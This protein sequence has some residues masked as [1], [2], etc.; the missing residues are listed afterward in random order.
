MVSAPEPIHFELQI[1][2]TQPP[3]GFWAKLTRHPRLLQFKKYLSLGVTLF[4]VLILYVGA[5]CI[6]RSPL[7]LVQ[8]IEIKNPSKNVPLDLQTLTNLAA[9]PPGKINL[10][11]L[12]LKTVE[13][14]LIQSPWI[15]H[16]RLEKQFPQTLAIT[17][18]YREP[19][20]LLQL[21]QGHLAY[22]DR[23]GKV[24]GKLNLS[25]QPD[26]PV[27]SGML[28][29]QPAQ[30]EKA[31]LV[32]KKWETSSLH[33]LTQIAGM[34]YDLQRGFRALITYPLHDKKIARTFVNLGTEF[35]TQE[36]EI[37]LNRLEQV[38]KY[39][40][41]RNIPSQQI[42]ADTGKKIIVKIAP[43]S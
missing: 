16:V 38:F 1:L 34:D 35:Q 29:D 8:N 12:H 15:R 20:A 26:L 30:I 23:D 27:F 5:S 9:V 28:N 3:Q 22:I 10:F 39:L 25:A 4:V 21:N 19:Q 18:Q 6:V 2:T 31:L 24:F 11:K 17:I 14:R 32:L 42:W 13:D 7:F 36:F 33:P 37:Q 41:I 40:T 43:N